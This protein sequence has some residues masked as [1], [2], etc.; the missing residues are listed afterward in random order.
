MANHR[1]PRTIGVPAPGRRAVVFDL[2]GVLTRGQ[3][4]RGVDA[5]ARSLGV[6][7]SSFHAA[8]WADRPDYDRG[9]LSG[10]EYWDRVAR[11]L[12]REVD[13]RLIERL[14]AID[15]DSWDR[16]EPSM[17]EFAGAVSRS[18]LAAAIVSN[19]P[20]EITDRFRS[21]PWMAGFDRLIFSSE[22]GLVKPEPAIF[23]RVMAELGVDPGDSVFVDDRAENIEAARA[24]GMRTFLFTTGE[25]MP[26]DV[27][28]FLGRG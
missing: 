3:S 12:T 4:Q 13:R 17:V 18:H 8:Y 20:P 26:S 7:P 25:S 22:V 1:V 9:V 19:S 16:P 11:S 2:F 10:P 14:I 28:A 5:M 6:G 23:E 24:L 15:V 27:E 21:Y